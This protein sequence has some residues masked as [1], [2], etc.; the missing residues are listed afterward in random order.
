VNLTLNIAKR[1]LVEL[2]TKHQQKPIAGGI[3]LKREEML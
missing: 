2:E 3:H 1:S